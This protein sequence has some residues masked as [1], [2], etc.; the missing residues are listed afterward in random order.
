MQRHLPQDLLVSV[1]TTIVVSVLILSSGV[2]SQ[3]SRTRSNGPSG[4]S[5]AAAGDQ[6]I[7]GRI[8]DTGDD[9]AIPGV[10][11][12]LAAKNCMQCSFRDVKRDYRIEAIKADIMRK[13]RLN[14]LPNVTGRLSLSEITAL[15]KIRE[16]Y[17][18]QNDSQRSVEVD[19][20]Y[21]TTISVLAFAQTGIST[22]ILLTFAD[23]RHLTDG[24]QP[25]NCV[26][27][28]SQP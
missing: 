5:E 23:R 3:Q 24:R 17:T 4:S 18:S 6:G 11:R 26:G 21:S 10:N 1:L 2:E 16:S 12:S 14:N 27:L 13:M 9:E 8:A 22:F 7:D 28:I 25:T 20:T 19:N 15:R